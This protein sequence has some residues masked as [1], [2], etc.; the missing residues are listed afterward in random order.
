MT[1]TQLDKACG[2]AATKLPKGGGKET[3]RRYRKSEEI[4]CT[5]EQFDAGKAAGHLSDE[6][7]PEDGPQA[8]AVR[9]EEET[10]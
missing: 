2:N 5:S 6:P 3:V 4:G 8:N 10:A 7:P 9:E 1:Q